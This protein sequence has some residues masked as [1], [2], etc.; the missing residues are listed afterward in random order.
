MAEHRYPNESDD[1]RKR[2]NELL[3]MEEDL[4]ARGE[5]VAQKRRELPLGG[6]LEESYRFEQAGDDGKVREVGFAD[7]FG[8]H[9][10]LLLYSMMFGPEWDAPCPACT[11]LVDGYN[12]T[13]F[14]L[15]KRCAM[16][17][18]AAARPQQLRDWAEG[19]GWSAVPLYSAAKTSYIV[20]YSAGVDEKD[21]ARIPMM[22][23]FHKTS[24]GI[25]HTWGSELIRHPMENGNTRH[26]DTVW[27]YWNLLDLTP[28]GRGEDPVPIQNF[29][30]RY[31]TEHVL[32]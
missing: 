27:L 24:D 16:A 11:S 28:D 9:H 15:S 4:R 26:V 14:P 20:D 17:V 32:G 8:P 19:R 6:K 23:C 29:R 21:P 7:L 10:T 3:E 25:F 13:Y 1:Y 22:N 2:R 30:H 31:F 18:V 12:S 5:A